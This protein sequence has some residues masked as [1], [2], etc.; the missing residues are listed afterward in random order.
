MIVFHT[1]DLWKN[2]QFTH[3]K[4]KQRFACILASRPIN[5]ALHSYLSKW[6]QV[7]ILQVQVALAANIR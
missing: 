3:I 6:N 1:I 4:R 2:K 5:I 7:D